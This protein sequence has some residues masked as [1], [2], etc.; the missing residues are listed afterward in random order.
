[1]LATLPYKSLARIIHDNT[2]LENSAQATHH[3]PDYHDY[4]ETH[5]EDHHEPIHIPEKHEHI[6]DYHVSMECYQSH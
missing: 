5:I 4:H 3:I 6:I 1:M 2:Q